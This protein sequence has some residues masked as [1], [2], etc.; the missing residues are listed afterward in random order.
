MG[1][2]KLQE[3]KNPLQEKLHDLLK[4]YFNDISNGEGK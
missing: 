2:F 1:N 4:Y 3:N